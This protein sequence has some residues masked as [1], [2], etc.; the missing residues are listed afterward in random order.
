[1]VAVI[2]ISASLSRALNYHEQEVKYQLIC[3]GVENYPKAWSN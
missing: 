1:M 3:L 2:Y